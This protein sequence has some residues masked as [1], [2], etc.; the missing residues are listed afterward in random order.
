MAGNEYS[1]Q[2]IRVERSND[3]PASITRTG[4][5]DATDSAQS[6]S[7]TSIQIDNVPKRVPVAEPLE[8]VREQGNV[9]LVQT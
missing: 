7:V 8:V 1:L 5:H 2:E 9:P 6:S 3:S 4:N